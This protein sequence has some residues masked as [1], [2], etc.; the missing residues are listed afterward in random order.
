MFRGKAVGPADELEAESS[1]EERG[2]K[3]G[4]QGFWPSNCMSDGNIYQDGEGTFSGR[5]REIKFVSS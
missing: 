3:S 5:R 4:S 1:K 2:G